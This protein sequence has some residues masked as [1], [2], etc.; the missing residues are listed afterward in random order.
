MA[1]PGRIPLFSAK[2]ILMEKVVNEIL[3][4]IINHLV[5]Y[6]A[7]LFGEAPQLNFRERHPLVAP[8]RGTRGER[9]E[10]CPLTFRRQLLYQVN[11]LCVAQFQNRHGNTSNY[12]SIRP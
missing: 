1:I 8:L 3:A 2:T 10:R 4:L 11:N 5:P 9:Q 7:A 6:Q 12:H